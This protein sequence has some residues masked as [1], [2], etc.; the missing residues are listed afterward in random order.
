MRDIQI[1]IAPHGSKCQVMVDG[2]KIP[3]Y[4]VVILAERNEMTRIK[5]YA[6]KR[7]DAPYIIRGRLM[8]DEDA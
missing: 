4:R 6:Y 1:S 5:I 3:A 8:E 7:D 2:E